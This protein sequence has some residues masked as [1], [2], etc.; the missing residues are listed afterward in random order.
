VSAAPPPSANPLLLGHDAAE[1][2]WLRAL[3]SGRL[4]HAWLVTGP[5]GVGKATLAYR[6]ARHLLAAPEEAER[7]QE[8]ASA[9]FRQVAERAH[10]DLIVVD[11]PIN[12]KDN[13][14][15]SE[16]PIDLVRATKR[17]ASQTAAAGGARLLLLDSFVPWNASSANALL[18]LLEEPQPGL[19]I[20]I[21][22][23]HNSRLPRT[24]VSR[25]ARLP[26]RPLPAALVAEGLRR[27]APAIA[28][29]RATILAEMARGSIGRA[30][31]LQAIDWPACY[32][33]LL[34]DLAAGPRNALAVAEALL[35]LAGEGGIVAAARLLGHIL[36]R[37]ARLAAGR[38]AD[39][40]LVE[41]EPELL[42]R[43][44][45]VASLDS[46]V[47]LWDKLAAS[48]AETEA[49][50]L[51]PLQCLLGLVHEMVA[52]PEGALSAP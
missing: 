52:P 24:I 47:A 2:G 28:A 6:L 17:T 23:Q 12:P 18:K 44:G 21:V 7:R 10:P 50:N 27:L 42:Q 19:V 37:A 39:L 33:R 25:C 20:L 8:P 36:H 30:L 49:L 40:R 51:D 35:K 15:K 31:E 1:A 43:L 11:E 41:G 16:L 4:P 38:P 22:A 46:C 34:G 48:A 13:K 45:G 26:L 9:I 32:G 14:R 3:R 5:R 29:P